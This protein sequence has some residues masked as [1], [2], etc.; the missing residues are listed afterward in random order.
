MTDTR[1]SL[2]VLAADGTM[3]AVLREFF[4][5]GIDRTLGCAAIDIDL[6]R[7]I[8]HSPLHTD[9]GLH[10]EAHKILQSRANEY[11]HALVVLD[12]HFGGDRPAIEVRDEILGNLRA[13]GWDERAEVV[14]IDPEL[15]VWLW[16]DNP[17]VEKA[18]RH[19]REK[20]SKSL[21]EQ[22]R[23]EK[24]WPDGQ[25]KPDAP[26]ATFDRVRQ[27]N[28]AGARFGVYVQIAGSVSVKGCKDPSFLHFANTLRA[29][30]PPTEFE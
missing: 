9:G 1:R 12:Q 11:E 21:R 8:F 23:D 25:L 16:Q 30:F 22:L 4:K 18:L 13:F 17:N 24:L 14:V 7:D 19:P 28:K 26:Q 10:K 29:W 3:E 6:R 5:K 20:T 2:V 15:E 27:R